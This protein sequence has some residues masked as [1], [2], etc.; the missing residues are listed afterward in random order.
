M[1]SPGRH[2]ASLGQCVIATITLVVVAF[3][4]QGGAAGCIVLRRLK[5][6]CPH[7]RELTLRAAQGV[8]W[9]KRR[10]ANGAKPRAYWSFSKAINCSAKVSTSLTAL[11]GRL[12]AALQ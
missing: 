7:F 9:L 4:S 6:H 2:N 10:R 12:P 1:A 3:F 8:Q 11:R 5:A